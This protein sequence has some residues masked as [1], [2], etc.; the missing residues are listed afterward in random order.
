[1]KSIFLLNLSNFSN[2]SL[3]FKARTFGGSS[4]AQAAI[5]VS[6]STDGV[7]WNSLGVNAPSSTSLTNPANA[8]SYNL[9]SYN[10]ST[11]RVRFQTLSATG[12]AGVGIDDII[13]K[14]DETIITPS[15]IVENLQV[16]GLSQFVSGLSELTTY[17]YRARAFSTNSTSPNSNVISVT[18][19]AAPPTFDSV[20]YIGSTVCDGANGT[21]DVAGLLPNVVSKIYY[22][23][24][25]GATQSVLTTVADNSGAA[26]FAI[27]LP[28]SANNTVLTIT[29]VAR[30]DDSSSL[31]VESGGQVFLNFIA[32]NVTYYSDADGDTYGDAVVTQIS[33]IGAPV[34]FVGNSTDCDPAD[35]TKWQL[36]TFFVDAHLDTYGSTAT[37]SVCSGVGAPSG[38]SVTND[39][40]DDTNALLNPTNPCANGKVVNL[41]MFIEGYYLSASTMNSVKFNQ[42]GIS[43]ATEVEDLT[44]ELHDA[45]TYTLVDTTIGTLNTDGTLSVTFNTAASGSYY[46]AVKGV[47][48]IETWSA[49]PQAVGAAP[50]SYD[51]SSAAVQAYGSN[52]REIE[53]G[54][55]AFYQGDIN[56]DGSIDNSDYDQLFPDIEN[57]NFGVVPTDLNGDGAVDNSDTD[58]IPFN[59]EN[60]IYSNHP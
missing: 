49:D 40:C 16:A 38:Y 28:L 42:D 15:F 27:P 39:D 43:P 4:A 33:C 47:N 19:T 5:T 60:S 34:G 52:M 57:S 8:F 29:T 31:T 14:G 35:G 17:H 20:S 22:N 26:T 54:V 48:M 11:V 12:T 30:A 24:D 51:F 23:I 44:V 21:F 1:M 45:T 56:Q 46:V 2:I 18:T 55:F 41:T 6:V 10:S 13:V 37:A 36:A 32:A 9:S 53:P 7:I 58:F 25:N 3:T 59:V 50:L